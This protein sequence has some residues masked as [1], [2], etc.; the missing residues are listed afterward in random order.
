MSRTHLYRA[1]APGK[2]IASLVLAALWCGAVLTAIVGTAPGLLRGAP[3][4]GSAASVHDSVFFVVAITALLAAAIIVVSELVAG[5]AR[6]RALRCTGAVLLLLAGGVGLL[7]TS[8]RVPRPGSPASSEP[9]AAGTVPGM[10]VQ[11]I[12]WT[13]LGVVG[14]LTV[15]V[16]G[17]SALRRWDQPL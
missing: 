10:G 17:V 15:L 14:A 2:P 4:H 3:L 5:P 9:T 11:R 1:T 6:L 16:G 7:D 8:R 13:G 12:L